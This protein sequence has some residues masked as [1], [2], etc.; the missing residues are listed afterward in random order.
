MIIDFHTHI[1]PPDI[2]SHRDDYCRR[3]SFFASLYADHK[4][5]LSTADD[6]VRTMDDYGIDRSVALNMHW[7]D[8]DLC[9]ETNEYILDSAAK[10][11]ERIIGFVSIQPAAGDK[12]VKELERCIRGG[13]RGVG[14]IRLDM[15]GFESTEDGILNEVFDIIIKNN[16][17]F[18]IHAS[19]PVGHQYPGKG[20]STPEIIYRL[21]CRYPEMKIA[22]AHMGGGLPFYALMPEV[23]EMLVNTYFDIAAIP[24]L[25]KE[26]SIRHFIE[27]LGSEK[28]LF[29]SDYP[30]ML[31]SRVLNYMNTVNIEQKDR[32]NI[33]SDNAKTLLGN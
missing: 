15:K 21:I 20:N 2:I 12:A 28:L 4:A 33:L 24:F 11:P 6:L 32:T 18:M 25:Y 9:I 26:K 31:P 27:I 10:Y 7:Q 30:L 29:G 13:A 17:V 8:N 5:V 19:E 23:H 22:C 16:L 1:V 14:E 3:D